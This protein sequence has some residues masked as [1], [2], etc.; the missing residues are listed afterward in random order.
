MIGIIN[1]NDIIEVT[2][3]TVVTLVKVESAGIPFEK[4]NVEVI[5]TVGRMVIVVT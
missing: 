5:A 4:T 2:V 3:V 1:N